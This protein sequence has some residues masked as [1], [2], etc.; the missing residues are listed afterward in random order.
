MGATGINCYRAKMLGQSGA[1]C[2]HHHIA[3]LQDRPQAAA[4]AA[5]HQ[6]AKAAVRAREYINNGA[7][8]AMRPR[9]Q[10]KTFGLPLHD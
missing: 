9:R 3:G 6:A 5:P 4:I 1:P 10:N 2:R 7:A 8:F